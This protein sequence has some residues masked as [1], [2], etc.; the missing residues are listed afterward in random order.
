[1]AVGIAAFVV[2]SIPSYSTTSS[3][4]RFSEINVN[5]VVDAEHVYYTTIAAEARDKFVFNLT[6]NNRF[7]NLTLSF[8]SNVVYTQIFEDEIESEFYAPSNGGFGLTLNATELAT[9][10]GTIV[11]LRLTTIRTATALY[12]GLGLGLAIFSFLFISYGVYLY[13]ESAQTVKQQTG[14]VPTQENES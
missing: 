12:F 13:F 2:G 6:T 9:V 4:L 7:V 11:V 14:G 10:S 8:K 3:Y 1:M 5:T